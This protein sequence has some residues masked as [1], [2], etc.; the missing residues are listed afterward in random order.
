MCNLQALYSYHHPRQMREKLIQFA[1]WSSSGLALSQRDPNC[2]L[3][4]KH[5][6]DNRCSHLTQ[7]L[8]VQTRDESGARNWRIRAHISIRRISPT[9]AAPLVKKKGQKE[10]MD[11]EIHFSPS[12]CYSTLHVY[13]DWGGARTAASRPTV[14]FP[15]ARVAFLFLITALCGR[16]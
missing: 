3:L 4:R 12:V 14:K 8:L 10:T 16:S 15:S 2:C 13:L 9:L 7:K 1:E 11:D 5:Q 6:S